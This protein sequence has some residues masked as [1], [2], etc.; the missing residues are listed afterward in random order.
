[1]NNCYATQ[2]MATANLHQQ[3]RMSS[4]GTN[5]EHGNPTTPALVT[6]TLTKSGQACPRAAGSRAA[7]YAKHQQQAAGRMPSTTRK[8]QQQQQQ[9][10]HQPTQPKTA[11][12]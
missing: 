3:R 5:T 1:M 7:A 9:Q 10:Y 12:D 2:T 11:A 6:V 4:I 8:Q